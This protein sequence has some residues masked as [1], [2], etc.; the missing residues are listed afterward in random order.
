LGVGQTTNHPRR[1]TLKYPK[2][3]FSPEDF[4][5]FVETRRFTAD[6]EAMGL[7]DN[8][9]L[10]MQL[11]IISNPKAGTV[12]RGTEGLRKLRFAPAKW[13]T[14]KSGAA[15][16]CYVYFEEASVVLL[17]RAYPKNVK[18]DLSAQE[19]IAIKRLI[20]ETHQE[21]VKRPIRPKGSI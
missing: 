12:M 3:P 8:A 2:H 11:A 16:V 5:D 7:N 21:L 14:G 6:W 20:K 15:R 13:K 4:L 10:A 1:C 9:L 18:D 17:M 19:R